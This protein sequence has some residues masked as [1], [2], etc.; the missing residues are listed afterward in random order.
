MALH[1][2]PVNF[3]LMMGIPLILWGENSAA[4]YGGDV[5]LKGMNVTFEWLMK[6]GVTNGTVWRIGLMR[7]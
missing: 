2:I 7:I 1:A 6:Y 4:E 5:S 3:A